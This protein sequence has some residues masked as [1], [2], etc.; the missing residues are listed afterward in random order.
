MSKK[1]KIVIEKFR[2]LKEDNSEED[3]N[4][5]VLS[6]FF[7][8]ITRPLTTFELAHEQ[9]MEIEALEEEGLD[10]KTNLN[11][12]FNVL[13]CYL[14]YLSQFGVTL[15]IAKNIIIY[16]CNRYT[17]DKDRTQLIL[18][19]LEATYTKEGFSE[20]EKM[21]I[22][23]RKNNE[24]RES[25]ENNDKLL[26]LH[27]VS[28]YINDDRTLVKILQ[29]NKKCNKLLKNVVYRRCLLNVRD[30]VDFKKREFLWSYFLNLKDIKCDYEALRDRI[31]KNPEII[32][33]VEEVISLD[34]QRSFNNTETISRENLSNILKTYAFYNPEIEYCQ[35][36]NF[37]AG[38]FYFY[39]RDEEKAFKAMLGLINKFDLTELFN[40]TLPRLKLYFYVLDRLISMYLPD[41]HDHFKNEFITS[42]LFSSAWFITCFCNTISH[43]RTADLSENILLFW[44]N[45][46]IDGYLVIFQVAI[47]LLG[48][49][50]DKLMPLSFEEMLNYIV[51]I[52]KILFSKN[53]LIEEMLDPENVNEEDEKNEEKEGEDDE[54]IILFD[55]SPHKKADIK[56]ILQNIDFATL[57]NESCITQELLKKI[58]SEYKDN[59]AKGNFY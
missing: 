10:S 51:D 24:L 49:F 20:S 42:S 45:F 32:E 17:L 23:L 26:I 29:F 25:L 22:Q 40:T 34:V 19:E 13:S 6:K 55:Q 1:K 4:S 48:I 57:L 31:N 53:E 12:I 38:F 44:D 9:R 8:R 37:L 14:R 46:V 30:T 36:M 16:F 28:E 54:E 21:K 58:E 33:K 50:E 27:L 7:T 59:E 56:E 43:Q 15:D 18:S 2:K 41:L 35:G 52:P 5:G 47:I 39:Y 3:I 11:I